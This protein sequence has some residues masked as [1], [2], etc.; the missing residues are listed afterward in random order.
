MTPPYPPPPPPLSQTTRSLWRSPPGHPNRTGHSNSCRCAKKERE[1]KARSTPLFSRKDP[2][3]LPRFSLYK[4]KISSS[5][6]RSKKGHSNKTK[7]PIV[8]LKEG[9]PIPPLVAPRLEPEKAQA[10]SLK[11]FPRTVRRGFLRTRDKD[12]QLALPS[13]S[14]HTRHTVPPHPTLPFGPSTST[15]ILQY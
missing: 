6:A 12:L 13:F 5:H 10:A 3:P 9:V 1:K 15:P 7:K 11:S 2:F 8:R 14:P 4:S